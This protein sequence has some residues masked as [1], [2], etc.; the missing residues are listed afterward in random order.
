MGYLNSILILGGINVLAVVGVAVLTGYTGLFTIGHAAFMAIGGYTA[1]VLV[2]KLGQ[3]FWLALVAAGSVAAVSSL[4]VGYPSLRSKLKGDYFAIAMLGFGEAVRLL[5]NNTYKVINGAI[6]FTGI[7]LLT[8]STL[9][10]VLDIVGIILV[11]NFVI[12]QYG[13]NCV[14]IREQEVA[15]ELMGIDVLKTKLWA[16]G[17]SA[18]YGGV[19]GGLFGFY[20]T[21]LAPGMFTS[22]KSSDLLAGVVFGGMSSITGPVL[23]AFLLVVLPELLRFL[24][25]WRLV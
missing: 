2:V 5:L 11:R 1:A 7:P 22:Q 12:S 6:G 16:L 8:T 14:A 15:A 21:Y 10:V 19:A 18:F 13:K 20:M 24:F 25:V 17:I 9:V 3:P 4:I 23:A